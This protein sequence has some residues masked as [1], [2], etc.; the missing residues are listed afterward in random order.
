MWRKNN[1][2]KFYKSYSDL[3]QGSYIL[4]LKI[5]NRKGEEV[6]RSYPYYFN[7]ELDDVVGRL[8]PLIRSAGPNVVCN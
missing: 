1:R 6:A 3:A 7:I 2:N 4:L 5:M 8:A